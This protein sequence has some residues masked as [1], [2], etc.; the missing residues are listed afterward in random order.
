MDNNTTFNRIKQ[1]DNVNKNKVLNK[2]T[3]N[4]IEKAINVHKNA[5]N[6]SKINYINRSTEIEIICNTCNKSF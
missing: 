5:F 6:Y 2:K 3:K 4:F 1:Y